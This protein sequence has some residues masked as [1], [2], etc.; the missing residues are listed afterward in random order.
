M[1]LHASGWGRTCVCA[2]L[3]GVSV[4]NGNGDDL[5]EALW[6]RDSYSVRVPACVRVWGS[7]MPW[8]PPLISRLD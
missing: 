7:A 3:G 4:G 5:V 8:D 1:S 2:F 6:I